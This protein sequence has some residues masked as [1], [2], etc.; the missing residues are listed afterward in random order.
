[1]TMSVDFGR[2]RIA[3]LI[4]WESLSVNGRM[5][6]SEVFKAIDD[7]QALL[8]DVTALNPNVLYEIGYAIG[9]GKRI[10]LTADTSRTSRE[11][12]AANVP[13]LA[14]TGIFAYENGHQIAAAFEKEYFELMESA[15]LLDQ[16]RPATDKLPSQTAASILFLKSLYDTDASVRVTERLANGEIAIVID[17]PAETNAR[18]LSWYIERLLGSSGVLVH[19]TGADR[20]GAEQVNAR[21]SLVSGLARAIGANSLLLQEKASSSVPLDFRDDVRLYVVGREA[22]GQVNEWLTKIEEDEKQLSAKITEDQSRVAQRATLQVLHRGMGDF[23]AENDSKLVTEYFIETAAYL[24]ALGGSSQ[25][26]FVGRKGTGKTATLLKLS[27]EIGRSVNNLVCVV[28]P[29]GYDV[30][31]LVQG[32]HRLAGDAARESAMAAIWKYLLLSEVTAELARDYERR[33][34]ER[35]PVTE[36]SGQLWEYAD[37]FGWLETTFAERLEHVASS[38]DDIGITVERVYKEQIGPLLTLIGESLGERRAI[39]VLID[40]VDK[41]WTRDAEFPLLASFLLALLVASGELQ[42]LLRK[43]TSKRVDFATVVFIRSDIFEHVRRVAR[44]PDKL[45]AT[46]MKWD[47]PELLLRVIDERF[48]AA[49]L[50]PA[51]ETWRRFFPEE[52]AGVEP[53]K[54]VVSQILPRPRDVIVLVKSAIG[55]AVNRGHP[56]VTLEDFAKAEQEY[57]AYA[58]DSVKVENLAIGAELDNILLQFMYGKSTVDSSALAGKLIAAGVASVR[59][60]EITDMLVASSILGREVGDDRFDFVDDLPSARALSLRARKFGETRRIGSR[61]QIHIAFR[62]F[63]EIEV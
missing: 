42:A 15:P 31:S 56:K 6:P 39:S 34:N 45:P 43:R 48:R 37:K 7:C 47:D 11:T 57:S 59:H 9:K 35:L 22:R 3:S 30:M 29:A 14:T 40:N 24:D 63:L 33:L 26:I 28:K 58:I 51:E 55:W 27:S 25:T 60:A 21:Y 2:T 17:D 61:F 53:R 54:Y 62:R 16:L 36:R 18:S 12:L 1:M 50:M 10:W 13:A 49:S 32:F 41:A 38:G 5:I 44:E 20:S 52:I 23:V 19:F 4:R 46:P 8:A